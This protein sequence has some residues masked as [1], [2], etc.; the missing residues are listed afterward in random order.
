MHPTNHPRAN[1]MQLQ[2]EEP[3]VHARPGLAATAGNMG[4]N[5]ETLIAN[6]IVFLLFSHPKP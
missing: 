1:V 3:G 2:N 5:L 4:G 6:I